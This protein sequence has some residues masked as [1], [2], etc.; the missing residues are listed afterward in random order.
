MA[1]SR[2]GIAF[3]V[4]CVRSHGRRQ[5]IRKQSWTLSQAVDWLWIRQA[6]P[7]SS[8]SWALAP[9]NSLRY[10]NIKQ[11]VL[12]HPFHNAS[13][14]QR[15]GYYE[16]DW[17]ESV[18]RVCWKYRAKS[19]ILTHLL[20]ILCSVNNKLD[21]QFHASPEFSFPNHVVSTQ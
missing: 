5:P 3:W 17:E 8:A 19:R 7:L 12:S 18:T 20:E 10:Q 13:Q 2:G 1:V 15:G 21:T 4:G 16:E 9:P 11:P 14:P 6:R